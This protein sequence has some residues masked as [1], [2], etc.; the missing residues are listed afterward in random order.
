MF[1]KCENAKQKERSKR[2]SCAWAGWSVIPSLTGFSQIKTG[3]KKNE[4]ELE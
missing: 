1:L 3:G 4:K 2:K